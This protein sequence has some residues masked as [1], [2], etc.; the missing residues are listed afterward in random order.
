[1][2]QIGQVQVLL[3]SREIRIHGELM[4][5]GSRAFCIL[6]MLVR[7][8]GTLVSKDEI[9]RR[10]WPDTVVEENNLQV[11]IGALRKLLGED[12]Q[13][14]RTV[15]GRG[16]LLLLPCAAD[17]ENLPPT[18]RSTTIAVDS[19]ELIGRESSVHELTD[20][21]RKARLVTLV[22]AG[23][24]GKTSLA[25]K[26]ASEAAPLFPAGVVFVPLASVTGGRPVLDAV[27]TA[28]GMQVSSGRVSIQHIAAGI[29]GKRML[30]IIDNCEHVID[31]AAELADALTSNNPDVSVL[32]TSRESLRTRGET[33]Y[34]VPPLDTPREGSQK[35][36]ALQTSAVQLFL[37]RVRAVDPSFP[38]HERSLALVGLVCRQLDGIPLAIELAA[39]RAAT[40]GIEVLAEHLDDRL[41]ILAGG[42]RTALP[43]HQTLKAT[44]DWSYR[45]LDDL[46]RILFRRLGVFVGGFSF[47]AALHTMEDQRTTHAEVLEALS[48]LVSKSL[49]I[50]DSSN[51][52]RYSLLES[53]RAYALQQLDD[54]GERK[55]ASL[56]HALYVF[57]TF[58]SAQKGRD[59][60]PVECWMKTV[61][62]E[63]GNLRTALDWAFSA[64]GIAEVGIDL[65]IVAAPCLY[66][67]S[68]VD[69]C[70]ERAISESKS[71][72]AITGPKPPNALGTPDC[73]LS[74]NPMYPTPPQQY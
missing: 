43:R 4:N 35:Q 28:L 39:A 61:R 24:I 59:G 49:V 68:L 63:L 46:E 41:R 36:E 52:S 60:R 10:V 6:E 11:Q 16:Y 27:A 55:L 62:D 32:A 18:T 56:A 51:A 5:L 50:H 8:R 1:M 72:T 70:A 30:L 13:L 47:R 31:A 74:C 69:E 44:F 45:L 65:S 66:E 29:A 17:T 14:I 15:P 40:L 53:T 23:G 3:E 37:S 7:A 25:R 26:V 38:S 33:L 21:L 42:C 20:L 64:S 67:I 58:T 57:E 73:T 22:G 19:A 34:R 9:M 54:H 48:G 12:R 2:V 71:A